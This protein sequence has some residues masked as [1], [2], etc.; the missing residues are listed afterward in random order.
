MKRQSRGGTQKDKEERRMT[1]GSAQLI[2]VSESLFIV[3]R[4]ALLPDCF[5]RPKELIEYIYI[6]SAYEYDIIGGTLNLK[7]GMSSNINE[8]VPNPPASGGVAGVGVL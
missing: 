5:S 6:Y 8:S 1:S 2:I 7:V 4:L 3:C